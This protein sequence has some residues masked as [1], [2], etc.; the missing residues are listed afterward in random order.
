M[1]DTTTEFGVRVARRLEQEQIGWLT[2]VG[3]SMIPQPNPVWFLWHADTI[4]LM[5]KPDAVKVRNIVHNPKVALNLE[6]GV[7]GEDV[8]VI[9]G[10]AAISTLT[11]AER[12]AYLMKYAEGIVHLGQTEAAFAA[13]YSTVLR[14][15]PTRLRGF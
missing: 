10:T 14:I 2:T 15:T 9:T 3:A 4:V 8:V 7:G 5:S 11:A 13:M 1:I 12:A 6:T